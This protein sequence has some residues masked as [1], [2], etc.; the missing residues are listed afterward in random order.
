MAKMLEAHDKLIRETSAI[1]SGVL[2]VLAL[3]ELVLQ[4]L[5]A[6]VTQYA[7]VP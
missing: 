2:G 6:C 4:A 5:R 3:V 7:S 1:S